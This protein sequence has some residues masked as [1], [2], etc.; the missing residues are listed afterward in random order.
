MFCS[1]RSLVSGVWAGCVHRVA[2]C[3]G[4]VTLCGVRGGVTRCARV[5]SFC[6][7]SYARWCPC[8][9]R[10]AVRC[11]TVPCPGVPGVRG[12]RCTHVSWS[13]GCSG[14]H[15]EPNFFSYIY[16]T[17]CARASPQSGRPAARNVHTRSRDDNG[18]MARCE[19]NEPRAYNP[20]LEHP[21][22]RPK[23]AKRENLQPPRNRYRKQPLRPGEPTGR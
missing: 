3:T 15:H 11:V 21:G 23:H 12:G 4:D 9:G 16:F 2:G 13:V 17:R 8:C 18:P 1:L 7:A 14:A 22:R 6:A 5:C 20:P 10:F 19:R